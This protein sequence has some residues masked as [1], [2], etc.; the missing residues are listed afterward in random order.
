MGIRAAQPDRDEEAEPDPGP[1]GLRAEKMEPEPDSGW[2][3]PARARP[4]RARAIPVEPDF[5]N[6][7]CKYWKK[8]RILEE[9]LLEGVRLEV[10]FELELSQR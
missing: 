4:D 9:F 8:W 1:I 10:L 2:A 3:S 6:F 5:L 7:S